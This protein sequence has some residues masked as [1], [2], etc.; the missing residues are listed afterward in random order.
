VV[1]AVGGHHADLEA[2][3]PYTFVTAAAD[4]ASASRPGARRES[5]EN[6]V[7]RLDNLE[8]IAQSFE[9]VEKSYA[10]QAGREIRILVDHDKVSDAEA[11]LLAEEISR[12]IEGELEYPGQIKIMVIRETRATA[13]AR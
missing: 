11:A 1:N 5:L 13:Y 9:G 10:I 6:Y 8:R 3:S 2:T 12:R 7:K 4:A